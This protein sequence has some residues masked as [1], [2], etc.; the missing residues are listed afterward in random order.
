MP[1]RHRVP[2]RQPAQR[3]LADPAHHE[4]VV[5]HRQPEQHHEQE[6]RQPGDDRAVRPEAQQPLGPGVLEDQHQQ[7]VRGADGEQVEHDRGRR[8]HHR[9]ERHQ[10]QRRRSAAARSRSRTAAATPAWPAKSTRRRGAAADRVPRRRHLADGRPAP[11]RSRSSRSDCS[12]RRRVVRRPG[13]PASSTADPAVRGRPRAPARRGRR[14]AGRRRSGRRGRASADRTSPA[15]S[16]GARTATTWPAPVARERGGE[17]VVRL[18]RRDGAGQVLGAGQRGPHPERRQRQQRAARRRR[19]PAP[20]TRPPQRRPQQRRPEPASAAPAAGSAGAG[21]GTRGRS[22]QRPSLASTAGS[23]VSEPSTATATTRIAPTASEEKIALPARNMPG[24][25][26]DDRAAGDDHRA[27]GGRRRDLHRVQRGCGPWPAPPAP[28]GRRTAS[29]RRRRPCRSA[30]SRSRWCRSTGSRCEAS[31]DRPIAAA[32]EDSASSTGTAAA[33]SAPNVDDQDDQGHRQAEH[34]GLLEVPV[35]RVAERLVD[36]RAA[37]LLDPQVRVRGLDGRRRVEQRS[38][39]GRPASPAS[40]VISAR[41]STASPAGESH[42]PVSAPT[43]GSAPAGRRASARRGGRAVPVQ[44]AG[45]AGDQHVLHRR[46]GEVGRPRRS[47]RPGPTRR[48]PRRRRTASASRPRRRPPRTRDEGHPR[49]H[50]PPPVL[51]APPRH[52]DHPA[53]APAVP[54]HD[55]L[56]PPRGDGRARRRRASRP[57]TPAS[58][59]RAPGPA[60]G[61][62]PPHAGRLAGW[63][64][65]EG[66]PTVDPDGPRGSPT[67]SGPRYGPE[68]TEAT[69]TAQ[70]ERADGVADPEPAGPRVGLRELV[71]ADAWLTT[72]HLL[73]GLWVG[74]VAFVPTIVLLSLSIGLLPLFLVGV[75]LLGD[76][77]VDHPAAGPPGAGPLP[78]RARC[79]HP[80]VAAAAA[81]RRPDRPAADPDGLVGEL[82]RGGLPAAPAAARRRAVRAHRSSSG[83]CRS[84]CSRCRSTTGRCPTAGP[85]WA[86]ASPSGRGGRP[87]WSACSDWCCWCCRRGWCAGWD[88]LTSPSRGGCSG[89]PASWPRAVGEL[90]RSRARVVDAAEQER[91]RIERDL[92]DGAQQRLVALAMNLGRAKARY[93]QDPDGRPR[94]DRRGPL[95]RQAGPRRAARPRPRAAPRGARRPRAG[96]R[97]VRARRPVAGAGHR[98][99]RSRRRISD[100]PPV[101]GGRGDRLLRGGRGADQHRQALP[102]HPR[103]RGRPPARRGCCASS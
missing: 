79:G 66:I 25:R 94:A 19:R 54:A 68:W 43:S 84:R 78:A 100:E 13:S 46:V 80:G 40:P 31:A 102:G 3:R 15:R 14:T 34:L 32:T 35:V 60:V 73:L 9:A 2:G 69:V 56:L 6:Q 95:R 55:C 88:W 30:G 5:V 61:V 37:D 50:R 75:P 81:A 29:S 103:R 7:A 39:R 99:G 53:G 8:D 63:E 27:P 65:S 82:A 48:P 36:G 26:D 91:R 16:A 90:E 45:P 28:G 12:A 59:P 101:P 93:D 96:R 20:A 52:P 77:T 22:T 17:P 72:T 83:P 11:G 44:R 58:V 97:A 49:E 89:R 98:R 24:H 4:D 38:D 86:S 21:T 70:A 76:H 85:R 67:R 10:H 62:A 51:G 74:I 42:R 57:A 47:A 23:T 41:T 87:C 64:V 33:S 18:H 92:H 1:S 71:S